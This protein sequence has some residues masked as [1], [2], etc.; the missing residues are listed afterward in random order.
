MKNKIKKQIIVFS[1]L[2]LGFS[3]ADLDEVNINPDGITTA[4]SQ[5]LATK[6]I[7]NILKDDVERTKGFMGH[8]MRDK[9]ILWSEFPQGQQYNDLGR[10]SFGS[11]TLL[12]DVEKMIVHTEDMD[13]ETRN[14]YIGLGHFMRA[15]MFLGRTMQVGD[16]PYSEALKGETEGNIKPKYDA[17]K[18]VFL[19]ILNEL[20]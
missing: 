16:I 11:L 19:G 15:Y 4:T 12:I 5:M 3:C 1:A 13:K 2:L 10:S 14:S 18:D 20:D 17:Q 6:M 7:L 8:F 9:Y